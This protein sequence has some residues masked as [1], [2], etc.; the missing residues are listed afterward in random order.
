MDH[1]AGWIKVLDPATDAV[2]D[3]MTGA[4]LPTSLTVGPDGNIYYLSYPRGIASLY[5]IIA[6]NQQAANAH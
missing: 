4:V 6:V 1:C 5:K 2:T 3:F